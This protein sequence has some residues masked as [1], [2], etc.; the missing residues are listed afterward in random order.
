MLTWMCCLWVVFRSCGFVWVYVG[1]AFAG[2]GYWWAW[3][4]C[5]VAASF[6]GLCLGYGVWQLRLPVF[7]VFC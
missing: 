1:L 4:V 3:V 5:F 7:R 6:W 2:F